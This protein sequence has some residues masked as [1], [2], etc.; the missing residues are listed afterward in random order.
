LTHNNDLNISLFTYHLNEI[1]TP[2]DSIIPLVDSHKDLGVALSEDLTW[3]KHDDDDDDDDDA[4][5]L[6]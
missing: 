4:N 6:I 1:L 3:E 5:H 2:S